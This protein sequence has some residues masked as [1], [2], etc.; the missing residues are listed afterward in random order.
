NNNEV[1]KQ[2]GA[3][4]D[5]LVDLCDTIS[6]PDDAN[7][8]VVTWSHQAVDFILGISISRLNL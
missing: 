4:V 6:D 1:T 7:C 5:F 2:L 3:S 8:R